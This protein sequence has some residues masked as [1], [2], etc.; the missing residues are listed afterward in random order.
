MPAIEHA[1]H[2][3]EDFELCAVVPAARCGPTAGR[4][5]RRGSRFFES[6]KSRQAP[7][8]MLRSSAGEI[9]NRSLGAASI[10]YKTA[11]PDLP[12]QCM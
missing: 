3:G 12:V 10:I 7:G 1:L 11:F 9:S 5:S 4:A 2:D 6:A 8:L